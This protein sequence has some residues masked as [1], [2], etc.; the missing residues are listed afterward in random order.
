MY[1]PLPPGESGEVEVQCVA[2]PI[3]QLYPYKT[4][5]GPF[6]KTMLLPQIARMH[7]LTHHC[8]FCDPNYQLPNETHYPPLSRS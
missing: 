7:M 8:P 6:P 4:L 1:N 3:I 5:P 2:C